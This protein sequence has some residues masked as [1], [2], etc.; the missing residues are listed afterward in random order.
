MKFSKLLLFAFTS[1]IFILS[2]EVKNPYGPSYD[3]EGNLAKDRAI[4]Q[5]YL[6]KT[7]MDSLYR[8]HDPSGVVVIVQ[9]EGN[10]AI[11]KTNN[12]IYI[13]YVGKLLDNA[14][15]DTNI[16]AIARANNI[17]DAN[18]SYKAFEF[19]QGSPGVIT[20]Y[21]F[22]FRNLKSGSKAILLIP[23]PFAYR[24][25]AKNPRI[26]PNS[27]LRFDVDFLGMD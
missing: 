6:A 5:D 24:D 23:S 4:I 8:I 21:T 10:G 2:C 11:P 22:G 25:D 15:F 9:K 16:E 14:V 1:S 7:P 3:E 17:F 18:R 26:P 20:G 27:V 13:N 19:I 12:V